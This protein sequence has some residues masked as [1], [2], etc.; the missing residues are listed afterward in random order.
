MRYIIQ[1]VN[2]TK[3]LAI[4]VVVGMLAS[5]IAAA[6]IGAVGISIQQQ[7]IAAAITTKDPSI[8]D[9]EKSA[10]NYLSKQKLKNN[11]SSSGSDTKCT[12][13]AT[14]STRSREPETTGTL[15][16]KKVCLR[17]QIPGP[18]PPCSNPQF[19]QVSIQITG[20]NP[21]PSS[22]ILTPDNSQLVTLGPGTFTIVESATFPIVSITFSGDCMQTAPGSTEATGTISAGQHLICTI[23]NTKTED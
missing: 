10:T 9:F 4:T 1:M 13:D 18:Q 11:C 16:I 6:L 12:N 19:A 5:I 17:F 2:H 7:Q 15:L 22:F 21:Q 14:Q 8:L 20:N 23:T 3:T